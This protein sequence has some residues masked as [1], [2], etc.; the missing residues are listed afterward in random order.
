MEPTIT[1]NIRGTLEIVTGGLIAQGLTSAVNAPISELQPFA[2]LAFVSR[3]RIRVRTVFGDNI[4]DHDYWWMVRP[5][6]SAFVNERVA[7]AYAFA[8]VHCLRRDSPDPLV[9]ANIVEDQARYLGDT[10]HRDLIY[11]F[12]HSVC[13]Q[14]LAYFPKPKVAS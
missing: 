4:E 6:D 13:D 12:W 2:G 8:L 5:S 1:A 3:D 7:D 14:L 10:H 11:S 9:L